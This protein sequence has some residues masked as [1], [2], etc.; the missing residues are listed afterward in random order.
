MAMLSILTLYNYDPSIFNGFRVPDHLNKQSVINK[1]CLDLAEL[2][3]LYSAP[4]V[5][6]QAIATWT[7]AHYQE[8]CDLQ[9]TLEYDY[10]PIWNVD[11]TVKETHNLK[12]VKQKSGKDSLQ[13]SGTDQFNNT[14][15]DTITNSGS[16]VSTNSGSDVSTN[17]GQDTRADTGTDTTTGYVTGYNSSTQTAKDKTDLLHGLTET[18]THGLTN[19]LQHGLTNTL[20]HGLTHTTTYNSGSSTIHGQKQ[21]TTYGAKD[22]IDDTGTLITERKGNIGVTSTQSLI[23]EQRKVVQFNVTEFIIK[24]FKNQFCIMVY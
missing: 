21:E 13:N 7:D 12:N 1:L 18:T 23:L 4:D 17:S 14:G 9:E 2:S 16:D 3:L 10:N 20:Q 5:M 11:G 15:N 19:T 6:K 24:Q 8:W 22:E